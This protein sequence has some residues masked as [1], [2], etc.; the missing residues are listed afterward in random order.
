MPN[1]FPL[2]AEFFTRMKLLKPMEVVVSNGR[3]CSNGPSTN[4]QL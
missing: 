4:C 3:Q 2:D 1:E